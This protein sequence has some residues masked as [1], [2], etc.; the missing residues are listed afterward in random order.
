MC[1]G[2][3]V[4]VKGDSMWEGVLTFPACVLG[5]ELRSPGLCSK[6]FYL[7][8]PLAGPLLLIFNLYFSLVE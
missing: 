6:L 3:P 2:V 1:Y 5:I 4:E 8:S 7:L